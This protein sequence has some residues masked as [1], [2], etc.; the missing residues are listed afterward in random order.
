[1][2]VDQASGQR[3]RFRLDE[4]LHDTLATYAAQ[5]RRAAAW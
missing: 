1:V 4:V 5:L 3:R 2:A